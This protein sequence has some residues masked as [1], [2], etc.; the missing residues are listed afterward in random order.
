M[1]QDH[2]AIPP[3]HGPDWG[4]AASADLV[5]WTHLPVAIWND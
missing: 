3:G 2:L 1:Y 5:H 4:H